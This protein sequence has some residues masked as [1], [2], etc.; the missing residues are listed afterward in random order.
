MS[1]PEVS[2]PLLAPMPPGQRPGL[3]DA[4]AHPPD[5]VPRGE[6]RDA[7][8]ET[9]LE[10]MARLQRALYA[11]GRRAVLVVLQGRDASGKDGVIRKV[12]GAFNPEGCQVTSF[13]A[14]SEAELARDYLWRVHLA[15][16]P[17]GRVGLFNRSHYEDV[18]VVRVRKLV[19]ESA[20]SRRYDQINAFERMLVDEGTTVLKFFL[21]VSRDEQRERL[22]KRLTD[23]EK[24]WKFRGGDLDDRALW[25]E[26]T[27]AYADAIA[28][29]STDWAPWYVV[30]A[31]K[32][33]VRDY[34]VAQVVTAAL[35]RMAPK[36]PRAEP[37]V[38]KML[39][40]IT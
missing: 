35:E 10:R 4:D 1:S 2:A 38:L 29:C 32:K 5:A 24:N 37:E 16:P 39:E 22:R 19:P 27:A 33:P 13:G 34:L 28:R 8:T 17:R 23:P 21:H 31:D 36:Y 40:R 9:L 26:Y 30:P 6:E 3:S 25:D 7:E 20:W 18:L 14:P 15:V 11:E 12:F